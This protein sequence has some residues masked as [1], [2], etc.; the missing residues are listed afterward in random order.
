MNHTNLEVYQMFVIQ[1][2]KEPV[3]T[4]H[5]ASNAMKVVSDYEVES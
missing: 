5:C 4:L 3:M 2:A 1:T